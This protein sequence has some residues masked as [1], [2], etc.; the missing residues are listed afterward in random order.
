MPAVKSRKRLPSRIVFHRD[1]LRREGVQGE[2]RMLP[3]DVA[4]QAELVPAGVGTL[5]P[6]APLRLVDAT[7]RLLAIARLAG[8]KL[9]PDKVLIEAPGG[10]E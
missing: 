10:A 2:D 8:T 1:V 5:D 3:L 6:D 9:A 7:G 4:R